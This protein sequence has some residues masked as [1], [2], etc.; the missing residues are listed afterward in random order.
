MSE[1][2]ITAPVRA[3][4]IVVDWIGPG[5]WRALRSVRLESL[6]NARDML[7]GDPALEERRTD[8]EWIQEC[9]D[10]RWFAASSPT[11]DIGLGRLADYPGEW[12]SLH[13]EAMWVHPDWRRQGVGQALVR[14]AE[15]AAAVCGATALGLWVI[16]P[17]AAGEMLYTSLDY[18]RTAR[19]GLLP[20]G[21]PE[22]EYMRNI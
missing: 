16:A 7:L 9:T 6:A 14:F 22:H 1:R 20:D 15:N 4:S 5:R 10:S 19:T 3:D 2:T 18:W 13:L 21:R 17:N 12:P 11:Q 8:A